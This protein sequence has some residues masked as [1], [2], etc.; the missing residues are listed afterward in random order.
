MQKLSWQ[1]ISLL[2]ILAAMVVLLAVFTSWSSS[3]IIAVA[4]IVA[5]IGGGA[6]AVSG[7]SGR[8]DDLHAE[9][10]AQTPVLA[11]VARRVDGELDDRIAAAMEEAAETGSARAIA[12]FRK[13]TPQ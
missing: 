11:T 12:A 10:T 9:T 8:V 2:G 1:A 6:A 3:D 13:G 7:L 4:S 5:G